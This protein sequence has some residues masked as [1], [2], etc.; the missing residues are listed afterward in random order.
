MRVLLAVLL[1]ALA[2]FVIGFA[3]KLLWILAAVLLAV[4]VIGFVARGAEGSRW[5]RW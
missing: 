4:W 5:Y 2:L 3:I 1:V